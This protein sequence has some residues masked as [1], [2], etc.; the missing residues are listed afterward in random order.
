MP[1]T[2]D[3]HPASPDE[4]ASAHRNVFDIWS[5]GLPLEE[6][7][8]SR[9]ESPK[10]R[11]AT[12]YV[13][14]VDGQVVVSLGCYPLAFY[15]RGQQVPGFSIGSVYTV[16]EFRG[17]G[18][19]P[20]LIDW[21]ERHEQQR[22]A[23]I[24]LLYSDINPDYYA[25]LGYHLCPSLE[26]WLDPRDYSSPVTPAHELVPISAGEQLPTLMRL[27]ADYHG[28]MPLAIARDASYWQALLERFTD[29]RFFAFEDRNAG[30]HGYVRIGQSGQ[31]LRITDYALSDQSLE[32]AEEFY[33]AGIAL[34]R[35]EG[36]ERFG[37][38]LPDHPSA[39]QFFDLTPRKTEIT[40]VKSLDA[41][42]PIDDEMA[43]L[44]SRFC[45]IDHV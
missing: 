13:G 28:S 39:M 27:Y 16:R 10:H 9:T 41:A 40:M 18:F 6:H 19:A 42:H 38:W 33:A 22:G 20:Q 30:W 26:G 12:W 36:A 2:L 43:E 44:A 34:A 5:K 4:L 23:V 45:E 3:M 37:G 14:C 17:H 32:L 11:L 8:R 31:A 24:S 29:D 15:F 35:S 1:P 21:A 25:Q 7:V